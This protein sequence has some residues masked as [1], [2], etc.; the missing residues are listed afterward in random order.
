MVGCIISFGTSTSYSMKGTN[1]PKL[2]LA[3][4]TKSVI[5]PLMYW[6]GERSLG[7]Q[8]A[9]QCTMVYESCS[10][11][12]CRSSKRSTNGSWL[13]SSMNGCES[14]KPLLNNCTVL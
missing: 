9:S 4:G 12:G 11:S 3:G 1:V 2:C 13:P 14:S 7:Y 10:G 5:A 8:C 6:F